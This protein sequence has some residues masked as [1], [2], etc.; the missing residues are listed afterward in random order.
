VSQTNR[1]LTSCAWQNSL[2]TDVRQSRPM[3]HEPIACAP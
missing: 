1:F 2:T 3:R